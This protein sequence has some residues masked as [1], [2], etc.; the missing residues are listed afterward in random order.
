VGL[1]VKKGDGKRVGEVNSLTS[2][3]AATIG[4]FAASPPGI[5]VTTACIVSIGLIAS[6]W[7]IPLQ[8][9]AQHLELFLAH[10]RASWLV[11]FATTVGPLWA[12]V[13]LLLLVLGLGFAGAA[14]SRGEHKKETER[15]EDAEARISNATS[16]IGNATNTLR[17]SS[18]KIEKAVTTLPPANFLESLG[19]NTTVVFEGHHRRNNRNSALTFDGHPV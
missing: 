18:D 6:I 13:F 3:C 4:R 15:R 1:G 19:L 10:G 12:S 11:S 16:N 5:A 17:D 2:R 9:G 7:P 14:H 8:Q